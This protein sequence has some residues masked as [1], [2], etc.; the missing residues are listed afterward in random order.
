MKK[1]IS[2]LLC[3]ALVFILAIAVV[4]IR[5]SVTIN[6]SQTFAESG[7]VYG[8]WKLFSG[9]NYNTSTNNLQVIAK[10]RTFGLWV[11]DRTVVLNPSDNFTDFKTNVKDTDR[12]WKVRLDPA[13]A[14]ATGCNGWGEI[15]N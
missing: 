1:I 13:G 12:N 3:V 10:H 6:S 7:T 14:N 9:S 5:Q 8:L 11:E 2:C 4:G 15:R